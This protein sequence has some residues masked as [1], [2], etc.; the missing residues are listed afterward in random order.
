LE[1]VTEDVMRNSTV[2]TN[3]VNGSVEGLTNGLNGVRI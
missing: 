2:L 1:R 3:G